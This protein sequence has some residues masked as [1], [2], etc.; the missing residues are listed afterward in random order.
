[1]SHTADVG[2]SVVQDHEGGQ[3]GRRSEITLDYAAAHVRHDQVFGFYLFVGTP[4]GLM[5]T[6]P[7]SRSMP[8]ALRM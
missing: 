5:I 1:M 8:L 2:E 4:L 7:R 3:V 6:R